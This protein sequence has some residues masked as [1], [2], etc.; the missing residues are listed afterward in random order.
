[1]QT[2]GDDASTMPQIGGQN[3]TL[4]DDK[5]LDNRSKKGPV[6][7][8]TRTIR[9]KPRRWSEQWAKFGCDGLRK[10]VCGR[11]GMTAVAVNCVMMVRCKKAEILHR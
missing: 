6:Y 11:K 10:E 3:K 7:I 2:K 9:P 1:M 8:H 4:D 5:P